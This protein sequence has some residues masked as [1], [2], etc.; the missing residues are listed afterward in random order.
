MGG[1]AEGRCHVLI[2]EK[3]P[4]AGGTAGTGGGYQRPD[5][6]GSFPLC[7]LHDIRLVDALP[8]RCPLG[9]PD[10]SKAMNGLRDAAWGVRGSGVDLA[11]LER[12]ETCAACN[13]RGSHVER[14]RQSARVA[15]G[16]DGAHARPPE[17]IKTREQPVSGSAPIRVRRL[18]SRGSVGVR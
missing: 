17:Q 7:Q 16:T 13:A 3:G 1:H 18:P 8:P 2:Y 15:R 10:L 4:A 12:F 14:L 5:Y 11:T 9:E 6:R